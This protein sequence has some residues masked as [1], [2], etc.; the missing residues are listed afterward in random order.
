KSFLISTVIT[1]LLIVGLAN[2]QSI[3]ELFSDDDAEKIAVID[4][5][6]EMF[7]PLKEGVEST[8]DD[9]ELIPYDESEET[10]KKAVQDDDFSALIV[11]SMNDNNVPEA[12][13]YANTVSEASEQ[14]A[15]EQQ[16]QQLKVSLATQ[17]AGIDQ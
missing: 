9:L 10:G 17:Q 8:N 15:I 7:T 3:I 1:L 16:L 5:S 6:G 12:T 11:L 2:I 13:Y 4:K 14:M